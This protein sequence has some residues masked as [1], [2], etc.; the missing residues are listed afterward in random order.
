MESLSELQN[1]LLDKTS[2]HV[3]HNDYQGYQCDY[4]SQP[5]QDSLIGYYYT[6]TNGKHKT[7]QFLD[8]TSLHLAV[9]AFYRPNFILYKDDVS[10]HSKD[11]KSESFETTFTESKDT[12]P[13]GA[14]TGNTQG[15]KDAKIQTVSYEVEDEQGPEYEVRGHPRAIEAVFCTASVVSYCG[16]LDG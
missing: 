13:E 3:V 4:P 8:A 1:P 9:E 15:E 7:Q 2:R 12:V 16:A 10:L 14:T 5:Y 6:G 11:S